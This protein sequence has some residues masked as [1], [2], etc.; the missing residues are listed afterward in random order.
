MDQGK[1]P[2]QPGELSLLNSWG[3]SFAH[4]TP[5]QQLPLISKSLS[6]SKW[7]PRPPSGF[8]KVNFDGAS[9]GNP[10]HS[11]YGVVIRNNLGQ[12]QSLL[13]KNIGCDTNNLAEI[14]GLI[15]R[16]QIDLDQSITCLIIE[17][18]SKIIIDLATKILNGRDPGKITP[19]WH[20][21]GPLYNV[22]DLLKPSLILTP[23]HI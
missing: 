1:L 22:Q 7:H 9:K 16:V 12:N 13:A 8:H 20:I 5:P 3:F 14:W 18:D 21:L 10:G 23:S 15:K 6:P 17:G 11:G 19:S 4:S 2:H